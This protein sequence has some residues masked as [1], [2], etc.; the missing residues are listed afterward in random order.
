MFVFGREYVYCG[1]KCCVNWKNKK[2]NFLSAGEFMIIKCNAH[3][4][5]PDF[6]CRYQRGIVI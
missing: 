1:L 5:I 3:T 4:T 2:N 6:H